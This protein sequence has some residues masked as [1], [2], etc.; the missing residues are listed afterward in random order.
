MIH[1]INFN[2]HTILPEICPLC[3]ARYIYSL[4]V[5]RASDGNPTPGAPGTKQ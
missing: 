1:F 3:N 4:S 2:L 5:D